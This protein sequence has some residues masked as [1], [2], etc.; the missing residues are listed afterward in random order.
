MKATPLE[1]REPPPRVVLLGASNLALGLGAVLEAARSILGRPIDV[2]G[3]I[4]HGRSFG[5]F[6]RVLARGL[7]GIGECGLWQA[8]R[9]APAAPTYA[10][11]TDVGNDLLYEVPVA[12]ILAWLRECL[13][14][15]GEIEA[16][17]VITRL[18]L[19]SVRRLSRARFLL[20]RSLFYPGRGLP[21]ETVLE[22]AQDLDGRLE[23][24]AREFQVPAVVQHEG[25]YGLDPIHIRRR[26]REAAWRQVLGRWHEGGAPP[27]P[28]ATISAADRLALRRTRPERW[29]LLGRERR[30]PQ[31]CG[32]LTDGSRISLY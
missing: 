23:G 30:R 12:T 6:S 24:L 1:R 25:W 28:P 4:G 19:G 18:P 7:P 13:E 26:Q 20:A 10:L 14:R 8:L 29:W 27:A 9:A 11:I 2:W 5:I 16:R 21:L 31:P 17:T 22:R 15:L 3:A 32:E